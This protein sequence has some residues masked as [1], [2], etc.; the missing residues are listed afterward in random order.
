MEVENQSQVIGIIPN[1]PTPLSKPDYD[2][3]GVFGLSI[4]GYMTFL[5]L[6]TCCL[7]WGFGHDVPAPLLVLTSAAFGFYFRK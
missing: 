4:K 6:A 3:V 1:Q 7:M 5:L 2:D